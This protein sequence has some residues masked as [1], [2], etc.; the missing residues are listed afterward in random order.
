MSL[1]ADGRWQ[2]NVGGVANGKTSLAWVAGA[3]ALSR[4]LARA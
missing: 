3:Y 1:T 4:H 2:P